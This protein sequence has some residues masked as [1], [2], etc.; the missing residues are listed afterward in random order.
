MYVHELSLCDVFSIA[1]HS[2]NFY[3]FLKFLCIAMVTVGL[4]ILKSSMVTLYIVMWKSLTG[5]SMKKS[6]TK[7]F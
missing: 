5:E 1:S 3:E 7:T 2:R 6:L 4:F